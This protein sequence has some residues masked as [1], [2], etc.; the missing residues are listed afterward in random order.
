MSF[1]THPR[2]LWWRNALFQIHLWL[3]II[4][5]VYFLVIGLTG[6][7]IVYK[8][9]LERAMIPS[10]VHVAPQSARA[11]FQ[12]MYDSVR[13]AYPKASISNVFLYPEGTSWSFR[14]SQDKERIQVYV[15]P[16]TAKVLGEDR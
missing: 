13:Q 5:G 6:S 10:L 16:Y 8:K 14:L 2:Q 11:S 12:A 4:I 3:G 1:L 15:D 7:L 9:E